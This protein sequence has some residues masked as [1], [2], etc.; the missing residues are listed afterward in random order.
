MAQL[1][2]HS[3]AMIANRYGL[4]ST[5]RLVIESAEQARENH[6]KPPTIRDGKV[7]VYWATD[8]R[9]YMDAEGLLDGYLC[10]ETRVQRCDE[11]A[12]RQF[13]RDAYGA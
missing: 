5:D 7:L 12:Y 3:I 2:V 10:E 4:E 8:N 9:G 11:L 13:E 6:G 1:T